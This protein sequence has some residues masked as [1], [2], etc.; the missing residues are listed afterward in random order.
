VSADPTRVPTIRR[1]P[2]RD[3]AEGR[4]LGDTS[5]REDPAVVDAMRE[6]SG[7]PED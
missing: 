2:L 7:R 1:R 6:H 5:A 4:T 3:I